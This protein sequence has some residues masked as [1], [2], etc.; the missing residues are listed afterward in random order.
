[1]KKIK[2]GAVSYKNTKPLL[3]GIKRSGLMDK[4]EL[5]ED[6]P[7]KIAALLLNDEI[8][9][10]LIPVAVI[11]KLKEAH[12]ISDFCIAADEEVASVCLF[13]E[14]AIDKIE[15]VLLDY[16]SKTSINLCKILLKN[17]WK[18][19]VIIE[20]TTGEFRHLIKGT[21]AAVVIGDRA[22]EQRKISPF[23][24]DLATA[25]KDFTGLPFVFAAWVAN[26]KIEDDFLDAF[27][28]AN[29]Y[30]LRHIDEI[31]AENPYDLYDLKKYYTKNI[32][33]I[34]DN[35]KRKGLEKF[36]SFL[37]LQV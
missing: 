6:Y 30:G 20:E 28:K 17:Y 15:K 7:A 1:M 32:S 21:T 16:Q 23:V 3:Y 29:A 9:I 35:Q 33:Y 18:K 25:W 24:Y 36:L 13:S 4:I 34:L 26:K 14:V 8:D 5:I 2:V 22:F 12:I 37:A 10:G 11:P 19:D 31:V 27:N